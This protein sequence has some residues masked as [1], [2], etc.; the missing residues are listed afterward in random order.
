MQPHSPRTPSFPEN[1]QDYALWVAT[2][3]LLA[4]YGECQCGCGKKT[5]ISDKNH[6]GNGARKNHPRRFI[7][8]HTSVTCSK[9]NGFA[10]WV[11]KHGLTEPYGMCQCG[12]GERAPL[13]VQGDRRQGYSK[14]EP[15][16]FIHPHFMKKR[17]LAD[18]FL[19]HFVSGATDECWEWQGNV[20]RGGYGRLFH[21]SIPYLA[22][23]VSYEIHTGP[24]APGMLICHE[25]D[26]PPCCNPSHLWQGTSGDNTLDKMAKGRHSNGKNKR[27]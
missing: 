12:C 5:K 4:P 9:E 22:H 7:K 11:A 3:G 1:L 2:Y 10:P 18:V 27:A 14:G 17:S 24:I 6:T 21:D 13:A 16:R 19:E 8:G 25:C 20:N 23:R 26:N 15:T